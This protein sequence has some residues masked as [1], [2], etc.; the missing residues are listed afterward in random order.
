MRVSP[1][2]A[3]GHRDDTSLL[4]V[5]HARSQGCCWSPAPTD[6][7][8]RLHTR[9]T[10]NPAGPFTAQRGSFTSS[11]NTAAVDLAVR[12][13]RS[14]FQPE[15]LIQLDQNRTFECPTY[16]LLYLTLGVPN[17]EVQIPSSA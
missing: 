10:K 12:F 2:L 8:A 7:L 3:F 6:D 17:T 9:R 1:F 11:T 15:K 5:D 13:A 14:D 16:L 4:G